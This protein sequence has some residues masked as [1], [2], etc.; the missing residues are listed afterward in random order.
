VNIRVI[1]AATDSA[2]AYGRGSLYDLETTVGK[3]SKTRGIQKRSHRS[4][5]LVS[6]GFVPPDGLRSLAAS[7]AWNPPPGHMACKEC[8]ALRPVSEFDRQS[9]EHDPQPCACGSWSFV[10]ALEGL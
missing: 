2:E 10:G 5:D 4:P 3:K 9:R 6:S 7:A 8:G 1:A